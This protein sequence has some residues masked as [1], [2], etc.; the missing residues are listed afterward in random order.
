MSLPIQCGI[1][2][3]RGVFKMK[4]AWVKQGTGGE[5]RELFEGY[6]SFSVSYDNMYKKAGHGN[7]AKYKFAF[8]GVRAMRDNTGKEIGLGPRKSIYCQ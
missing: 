8:W 6:F 4:R 1:K 2:A 7:G 5:W 3:S